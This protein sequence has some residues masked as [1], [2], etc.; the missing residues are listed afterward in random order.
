MLTHLHIR[1]FKAWRDTQAIRLAP[2][3]VFFG[4]NSS[5]KSSINQL[6][7]MLKQTVQSADRKMALH[8]GDKNTVVALGSFWDI[9]HSHNQQ[10]KITFE[11]EW[12]LLKEKEIKD[13]LSNQSFHGNSIKFTAEIGLPGGNRQNMVVYHQSYQLGVPSQTGLK[14]EMKRESIDPKEDSY[15]LTAFPYQ[16]VSGQSPP[17]PHPIHF[18][19]FPS[20]VSAKY[21]NADFVYELT[22][23][24][25]QRLQDIYYLG[26]LRESPQRYYRWAGEIPES[27]GWR[28]ER[29]IDAVLAARDQQI[30]LTSTNKMLPFETII[31]HWLQEMGLIESFAVKQVA[32]HRHDYE[33]LVKTVGITDQ[34]N[35]TDVGLGVSQVLPVLVQCFYAPS[36]STTILE[37]PEVHLHPSAQA[38]L[39]DVF[40]DA[41]QARDQTGKLHNIQLLIESHSEHFLRRL[42]RRIAEQ[43]IRP[44]DTA[45]YFCEMTSSGSI[46]KPLDI[47]DYGNIKNW[48]AKFFGDEVG[49]LT[50]MTEAAIQRQLK[51]N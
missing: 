22:L 23:A 37:Q 42:Q 29:T 1:N 4:A 9:V 21:E 5:G 28:G 44:L 19:G 50:A 32:S 16:L 51:S 15:L 3:T 30:N 13:R 40:I 20:E 36:D 49:D 46:L 33:V 6:L 18:Y 34:V 10:K 47:D 35:L 26:A 2:L 43:K 7:L 12:H 11:L 48:P 38:V 24:L 31:F 41:I 39:A 27:V 25:E 8:L 14:V 17:L 45:I